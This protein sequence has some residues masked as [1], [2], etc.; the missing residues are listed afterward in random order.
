[1]HIGI[2]GYG[3][4]GKAVEK[5]AVIK[6]HTVSILDSSTPWASPGFATVDCAI[7]FSDAAVA[8][9][10]V[11]GCLERGTNVV[12]GTTGWV[13]DELRLASICSEHDVSFC[14][15]PNF[16]IGMQIVFHLNK[17]L[18][19]I[20]N[21]HN[22]FKAHILEIHHL[23]KRDAPSGTAIALGEQ[24]VEHIDRLEKWQ[25]VEE[26]A[27]SAA[28][29]LP[30][31]ARRE[32]D[33]KGI[34]RVSYTGPAESISLRHHALSRDGFALGAIYAAERLQGRVGQF[35]FDQLLD[36]QTSS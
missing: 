14:W 2:I 11:S 28:T 34:H 7:D 17:Q 13:V 32:E 25:L 36:F 20:M 4:M 1:M 23:Q 16:S 3:K 8:E 19:E 35:T 22:E 31:D 9:T 33:V 10:A 6:G 30:I 24:I 26:G 18:A 15:A 5:H 12:S 29:S 27:A 21:R